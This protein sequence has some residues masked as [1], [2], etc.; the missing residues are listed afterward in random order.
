[1]KC[2]RHGDRRWKMGDRAEA[3]PHPP[4]SISNLRRSAAIKAFSLLEI[5]I[6]LTVF[7]IAISG[8]FA[9]LQ[10]IGMN[11]AAFAQDRGIQYGLEAILT[12]A[13]HLPVE[14]MSFERMDEAQ[15]VRYTVTAEPASLANIDGE[16][17]DDLYLLRAMADFEGMGGGIQTEVAEIYVYKPEEDQ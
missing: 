9:A 3:L 13:K 2:L 17:L 5:V 14:E 6:A 15:G 4:S 1:M 16:A 8:L 11:S 10:Q 7:V 12:E